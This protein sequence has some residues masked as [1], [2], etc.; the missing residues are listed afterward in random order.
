MLKNSSN[1]EVVI[2]WLTDRILHSTIN[3]EPCQGSCFYLILYPQFR[4][5]S[6][7]VIHVKSLTGFSDKNSIATKNTKNAHMI[8]ITYI[9]VILDFYIILFDYLIIMN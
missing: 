4:F 6:L 1:Y 3:I 2:R 8:F 9:L 5:T 7:G